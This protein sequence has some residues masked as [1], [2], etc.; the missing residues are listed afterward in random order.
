ML[1][2]LPGQGHTVLSSLQDWTPAIVSGGRAH[3][4]RHQSLS[5]NIKSNIVPC[6]S[7]CIEIKCLYFYPSFRDL[8]NVFVSGYGIKRLIK[9]NGKWIHPWQCPRLVKNMTDFR[10]FAPKIEVCSSWFCGI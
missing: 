1:F 10:K 8:Q 7:R 9:N 2:I 3:L 4:L 5:Q 6:V